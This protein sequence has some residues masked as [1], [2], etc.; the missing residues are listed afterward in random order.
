MG[1]GLPSSHLLDGVVADEEDSVP[2][3]AAPDPHV[4][5]GAEGTAQ[6]AGGCPHH[7]RRDRE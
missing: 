6:A 3:R 4:G 1:G 7:L 2:P 5:A